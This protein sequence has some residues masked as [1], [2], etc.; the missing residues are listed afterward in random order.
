MTKGCGVDEIYVTSE[1]VFA[2]R[3]LVVIL[4]VKSQKSLLILLLMIYSLHYLPVASRGVVR[5]VYMIS[6]LEMG[7]IAFGFKL[8]D[9]FVCIKAYIMFNNIDWLLILLTGHV[10][11]PIILQVLPV[12]PNMSRSCMGVLNPC[13]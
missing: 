13:N 12:L 2:K 11:K 1:I 8:V 4:Q 10:V 6:P 3:M 7:R 5:Y 9:L